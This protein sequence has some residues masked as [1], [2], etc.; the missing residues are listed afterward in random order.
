MVKGKVDIVKIAFQTVKVKVAK[1]KI[2]KAKQNE[3]EYS[4]YS[5]GGDVEEDFENTGM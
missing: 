3:P 2:V 5:E 1:V 4:E